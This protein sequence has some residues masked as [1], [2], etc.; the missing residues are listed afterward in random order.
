MRIDNEL[1]DIDD[2]NMVQE[3]IESMRLYKGYEVI[4]FFVFNFRT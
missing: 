2:E 4:D 1:H 3:N